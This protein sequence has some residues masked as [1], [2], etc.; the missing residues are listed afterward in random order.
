MHVVFVKFSRQAVSDFRDTIT[1]RNTKTDTLKKIARCWM[2]SV[3]CRAILA[4]NFF[5]ATQFLHFFPNGDL[6]NSSYFCENFF[7][8][9]HPIKKHTYYHYHYTTFS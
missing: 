6:L 1:N 9:L 5:H 8:H 3:K 2:R 4:C 7:E